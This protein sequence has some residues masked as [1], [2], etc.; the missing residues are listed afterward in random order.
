VDFYKGEQN[1][2]PLKLAKQNPYLSEQAQWIDMSAM[3]YTSMQYG[4]REN[5]AY[6]TDWGEHILL[7]RPDV[8]LYIKLTDAYEYLRDNEHYC[9]T[10]KEGLGMYPHAE[11][12]KMAVKFCQY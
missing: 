7:R 10:A 6:F 1:D 9:E 5:V 3:M 2:E 8:D 4:A 12:L 11:R